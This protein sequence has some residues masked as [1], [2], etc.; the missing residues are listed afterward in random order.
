MQPALPS[1][2]ALA[3]AAVL[4]SGTGALPGDLL[5]C[6]AGSD[7]FVSVT[8]VEAVENAPSAGASDAV[9]DAA[10]DTAS[11]GAGA[12]VGAAVAFSAGPGVGAGGET[13]GSGLV[14]TG[15]TLASAMGM[16][17][18]SGSP[19]K[20]LSK[21]GMESDEEPLDTCFICHSIITSGSPRC[22]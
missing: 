3:G 5:D 21:S 17:P 14:S 11:A 8:V 16:S 15:S 10:V 19:S 6:A 1:A 20:L 4:S 2:Y 7:G 22:P 13:L 18:D 9:C 12:T